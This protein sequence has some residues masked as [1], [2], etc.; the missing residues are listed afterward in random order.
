MNYFIYSQ[1]IEIQ[2]KMSFQRR[3]CK[4]DTNCFCYICGSFTT[5]KQRSTIS[6]FTKKAYHAYFGVKL[7]DQDKYWAPHSVCRTCVENLRQWT[8]GTRKGLTLRI[9]MIWREP[10]DHF[11]DC[12]FCLTSVA[13][14][15]SKTKSSIQYPSLSSAIRPV[16]HS[17]QIPISDS[18]V[19]GNLSESNS[20]SI[21]TKSSDGNDPEYMDIAVGSQSPQ[22][23]SQCELNDLVRD[24]DLSKEA[25]ELLGS[26]LSEKN[27]LAQGTTFS[28]YRYREKELLPLFQQE[29]D[30][31]FC[32][33]IHSLIQ[34]MGHFY[35]PA[36]W[37]LFIDSSK[38]S[39]KCVLLHNGNQ[40]ACIPIGYSVILKESY[41][42]MKK[43][44]EKINYNE[45]D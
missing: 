7:G 9:P 4:T 43:I 39:L 44:L 41:D 1:I 14:H 37:R 35:D 16:P 8:K 27:L 30:F 5:P 18:V 6:E 42:N 17:E 20:D 12:Y 38:R 40:L 23:F 19:F 21:S 34:K 11:S 33:D 45:H 31:V 15:S 22:L 26:R 32:S 28:F 25:A 36:D 2:I 3:K 13:G 10:K 24:L 29:D